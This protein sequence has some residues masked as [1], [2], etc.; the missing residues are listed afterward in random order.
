MFS[1]PH[2]SQPVLQ[3]WAES[4]Q[5]HTARR[6]REDLRESSLHDTVADSR[7][8]IDKDRVGTEASGLE[9]AKGKEG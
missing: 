9:A 2:A 3:K 7:S 5:D 4:A 1:K 8:E 6:R